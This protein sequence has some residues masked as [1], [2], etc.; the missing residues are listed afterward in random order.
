MCYEA[1]ERKT[2]GRPSVK[3]FLYESKHPILIE[4]TIAQIGILP[5]ADYKLPSLSGGSGIN[6]AFL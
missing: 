2:L 3:H 1:R 4:V 6:P 5:P